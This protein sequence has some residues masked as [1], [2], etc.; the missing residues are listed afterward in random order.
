[1]SETSPGRIYLIL[2]ADIIQ[3]LENKLKLFD[4]VLSQFLFKSSFYSFSAKKTF[5]IFQNHIKYW[6]QN[7]NNEGGKKHTEGETYGHWN[8][9]PCL[10][11]LLKKHGQQTEKSG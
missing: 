1:M 9:E 5:K 8:Q 4:Y 2:F 3:F 11:R 6:S 10:Q 7:K